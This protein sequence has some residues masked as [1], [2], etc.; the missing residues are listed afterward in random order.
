MVS[1]AVTTLLSLGES[2]ALNFA[3]FQQS[4][5][6]ERFTTLCYF[7]QSH[8]LFPV[9]H[10]NLDAIYNNR[11]LHNKI[12]AVKLIH[13]TILTGPRSPDRIMCLKNLGRHHT[14]HFGSLN[15]LQRYLTKAR[16]ESEK[17]GE[18]GAQVEVLNDIAT[19]SPAAGLPVEPNAQSTVPSSSSS[20]VPFQWQPSTNRH[21]NMLP[22]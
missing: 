22:R 12:R 2:A 16:T 4:E 10:P 9:H 18:F 5:D 6:L 13:V 20:P 11:A 15:N 21:C 14:L 17:E 8:E 1:E 19:R 3:R 7:A